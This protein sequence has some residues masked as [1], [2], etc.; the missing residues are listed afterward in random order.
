[1]VVV[2]PENIYRKKPSA[3]NHISEVKVTKVTHTQTQ[4]Y[5][6]AQLQAS[7]AE[8]I[9]TTIERIGVCLCHCM[10]QIHRG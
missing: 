10:D 2:T 3:N 1:M 8:I 9:V 4:R 5:T 7:R 6:H